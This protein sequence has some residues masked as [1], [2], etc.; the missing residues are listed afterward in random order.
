VTTC[1]RRVDLHA[2]PAVSD[3]PARGTSHPYPVGA[4]LNRP[5]DGK[6]IRAIANRPYT[7]IAKE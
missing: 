1:P 2:V 6:D 4:I 7:L 5:Q 3:N